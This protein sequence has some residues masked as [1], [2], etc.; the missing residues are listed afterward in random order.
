MKKFAILLIGTLALAGC[1]SAEKSAP[2]AGA[3][4][5]VNSACPYSGGKVKNDVTSEYKG[6]TI[7]FCCAGCKA[8]FD[9]GDD[10]AKAAISAKATQK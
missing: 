6:Q 3:L 9:G 7:G 10:T 8:K 1:S 5:P 4:A 2:A